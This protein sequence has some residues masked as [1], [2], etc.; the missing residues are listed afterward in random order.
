VLRVQG[1]QIRGRDEPYRSPLWSQVA[2]T[3]D[4]LKR[5]IVELDAGGCRSGILSRA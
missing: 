2:K 4:V 1:P 3:S 5:L